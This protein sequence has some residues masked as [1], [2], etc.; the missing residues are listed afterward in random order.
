MVQAVARASGRRVERA[1]QPGQPTGGS[2]QPRVRRKVDS[3]KVSHQ[4]VGA[5]NTTTCGASPPVGHPAVDTDPGCTAVRPPVAE[6]PS[7]GPVGPLRFRCPE[8][9]GSHRREPRA[10]PHR[11]RS[12]RRGRRPRPARGAR[13]ARGPCPRHHRGLRCRNRNGRRTQPAGHR[14]ACPVGGAHCE[15]GRRR[16]PGPHWT[17]WQ[18]GPRT[19]ARQQTAR[20]HDSR[21]P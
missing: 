17:S 20:G 5:A 8:L 10:A 2:V 11:T 19:P 13:P 14:T 18:H 7:P 15:P 9:V 4:M 1:P 12:A 6:A 16:S 21:S 3:A